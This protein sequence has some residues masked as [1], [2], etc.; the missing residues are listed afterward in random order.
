MSLTIR[1]ARGPEDMN[2]T[3]ELFQ[4]YQTWLDV[5]L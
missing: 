2:V 4:E 1:P 5:D 3:R